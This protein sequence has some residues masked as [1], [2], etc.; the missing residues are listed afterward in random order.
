MPIF[1]DYK[2]KECGRKEEFMH[3]NTSDETKPVCPE[4]H[5]EME[6]VW[7]VP[8]I[9]GMQKDWMAGKSADQIAGVLN[10]DFDP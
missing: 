3:P 10:D 9:S 7:K 8:T 5:G 2:C 1:K 4:G 6:R